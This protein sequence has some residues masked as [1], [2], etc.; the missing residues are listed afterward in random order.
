MKHARYSQSEEADDVF[1][2]LSDARRRR[3]IQY[4]GEAETPVEIET[5]AHRLQKS[6]RGTSRTDDESSRQE[7]VLS[8]WHHH[9][10][11][12]ANADIVTLDTDKKTIQKG[13]R[14]TMAHSYLEGMSRG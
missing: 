13:D 14:F 8:L 7:I 5:A 4:L 2:C 12:L 9:L 10:P 6:G 3:L 1:L 11:K